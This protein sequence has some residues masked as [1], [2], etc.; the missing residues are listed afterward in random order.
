MLP[1]ARMR[2]RG[3]AGRRMTEGAGTEQIDT[4]KPEQFLTHF[5]LNNKYQT[6]LNSIPN[7]LSYLGEG[8]K[9]GRKPTP[10]YPVTQGGALNPSPCV[11]RVILIP[12]H[13]IKENIL[14]GAQHI[15]SFVYAGTR[16]CSLL[17]RH[18]TELKRCGGTATPLSWHRLGRASVC[19][20]SA[21]SEEGTGNSRP[22][23]LPSPRPAAAGCPGRKWRSHTGGRG[24]WTDGPGPIFGWVYRT[25]FRSER[26]RAGGRPSPQPPHQLKQPPPTRAATAT[27]TA[28]APAAPSA[29]RPRG[30][31]PPA[32]QRPRRAAPREL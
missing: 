18:E 19:P 4:Q 20:I 13:P 31:A 10:R 17:F 12:G 5:S 21:R 15:N 3:T 14:F 11:S 27:A 25:R 24:G 9:Q 30:D 7:I 2:N 16:R 23:A 32:A 6:Y 8:R 22:A 28:P 26:G 29:P 1:K